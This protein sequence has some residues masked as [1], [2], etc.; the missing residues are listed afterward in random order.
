[1]SS[2]REQGLQFRFR[3]SGD[4][5]DGGEEIWQLPTGNAITTGQL[6]P[7]TYTATVDATDGS[8]LGSTVVSETVRCAWT[9]VM[10]PGEEPS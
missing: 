7:G 6:A 1:M 9:S 8:G 10:V 3:R 5:Q 2:C 4:G